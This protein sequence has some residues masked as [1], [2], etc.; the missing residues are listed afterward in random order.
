MRQAKIWKKSQTLSKDT[1]K[2]NSQNRSYWNFTYPSWSGRQ[3]GFANLW[4]GSRESRENL[5]YLLIHTE[6]EALI[7]QSRR[8][9]GLVNCPNFESGPHTTIIYQQQI[10][11]ADGL[12]VFQ[13][14]LCTH[15]HW[16]SPLTKEILT[17]KRWRKIG[18]SL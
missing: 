6:H 12:R 10:M 3:L 4:A 9:K 5:S 15:F 7:R 13:P 18:P 2:W 16:R 1:W 17:Q 8:Y 14:N 11:N